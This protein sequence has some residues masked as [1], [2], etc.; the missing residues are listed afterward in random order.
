MDAYQNTAEPAEDIRPQ[1]I[2]MENVLALIAR[3]AQILALE[4]DY[5]AEMDIQAIDPLQNEKKWLTKA[6]ELQLKRVQKY[7]YLLEAVTYEEREEFADMISV[8]NEIKQENHRRLLAARDVN[9]RV[10]EAITEVVNEH[11]RKPNYDLR[12]V[13]ESKLDSVSVTLNE[14]V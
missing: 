9:A 8:F 1:S 11:N 6:V 2:N 4:V 10:V 14:Q 12:G 7:P 5:L 13:P 3:L